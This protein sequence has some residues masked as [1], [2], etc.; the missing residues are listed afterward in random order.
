VL[1]ASHTSKR[2]SNS[3]L[4]LQDSL[5]FFFSTKEAA[6]REFCMSQHR[7]RRWKVTWHQSEESELLNF[8]LRFSGVVTVTLANGF[9][10][11]S[12]DIPSDQASSF[13]LPLFFSCL[14]QGTHSWCGG[15]AGAVCGLL[16]AQRSC[17]SELGTGVF[18]EKEHTEESAAQDDFLLSL[19]A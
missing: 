14:F 7:Q 9:V 18:A 13:S 16:S 8:W 10:T 11:L 12:A 17:S 19:W 15:A 3:N 2:H 1:S 5:G 6:V 4:K